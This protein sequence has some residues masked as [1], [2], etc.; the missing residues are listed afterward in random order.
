MN[1]LFIALIGLISLFGDVSAL[2]NSASVLFYTKTSDWLKNSH[3]AE[4]VVQFTESK[5]VK[6]YTIDM[7]LSELAEFSPRH[8]DVVNILQEIPHELVGTSIYHLQIG[9]LSRIYESLDKS[10]GLT[11]QDWGLLE[12]EFMVTKTP[13]PHTII[14]GLAAAN[15]T[16]DG[17]SVVL[18]TET[19]DNLI[20]KV[21]TFEGEEQYLQGEPGLS[22]FTYVSKDGESRFRKVAP[23]IHS[24]WEPS[25]EQM[26]NVTFVS[27][28]GSIRSGM[29]HIFMGIGL[30]GPGCKT[31]DCFIYTGEVLSSPV[32]WTKVG[33]RIIRIGNN[34]IELDNRLVIHKGA[35]IRSF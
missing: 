14:D 22:L 11:K 28:I 26:K 9:N 19:S 25:E 21:F 35:P 3:K 34:L 16:L 30:T 32:Q 15:L 4:L 33:N 27:Y 18:A 29:S 6:T 20:G 1:Y 23:S 31:Q 24:I 2:E 12:D 5:E 7:D 10:T 17:N 8:G 13:S